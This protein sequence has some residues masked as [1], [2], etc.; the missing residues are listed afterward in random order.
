LRNY[1]SGGPCSY[2]TQSFAYWR[3]CIGIDNGGGRAERCSQSTGP[4][5]AEETSRWWL[6]GW[7]LA[8]MAASLLAMTGMVFAVFL[9]GSPALLSALRLLA[10]LTVLGVLLLSLRL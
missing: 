6:E 7:R 2:S 4:E 1:E 5:R 3:C 10:L 9:E 8:L